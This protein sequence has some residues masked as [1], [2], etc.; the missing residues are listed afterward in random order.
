MMGMM[1]KLVLGTGE[2]DRR[3]WEITGSYR[4]V[5]ATSALLLINTDD[6]VWLFIC[7]LWNESV[8]LVVIRSGEHSWEL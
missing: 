7:H 5:I 4:T 3:I 8:S 6:I 2:C 1:P